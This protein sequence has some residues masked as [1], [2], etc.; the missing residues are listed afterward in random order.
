MRITVQLLRKRRDK[1]LAAVDFSYVRLEIQDEHR[2]RNVVFVA[3]PIMTSMMHH[4]HNPVWSDMQVHGCMQDGRLRNA[5]ECPT[6]TMTVWL[7]C[8][9]SHTFSIYR[10]LLGVLQCG[11]TSPSVTTM[12]AAYCS[13]WSSSACGG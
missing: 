7:L 13:A 3:L 5:K 11:D 9:F 8:T 12:A 6:I 4:N 10:A 2:P 1:A